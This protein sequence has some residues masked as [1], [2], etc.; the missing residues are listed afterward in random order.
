M[1]GI[2]LN[3]LPHA[4]TS[5]SISTTFTSKLVCKFSLAKIL[6]GKSSF[7]TTLE[8]ENPGLKLHHT[9]LGD[10][11][12]RTLFITVVQKSQATADGKSP[13]KR[14]FTGTGYKLEART[15]E[16]KFRPAEAAGAAALERA[17][18]EE[19]KRMTKAAPRELLYTAREAAARGKVPAV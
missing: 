15:P 18:I 1:E 3:F 13:V 6:G 7:D 17:A 5:L 16:K 4:S 10:G 19:S 9:S 14:A 12:G 11:R 2:E 8:H